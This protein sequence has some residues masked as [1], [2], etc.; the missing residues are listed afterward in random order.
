MSRMRLN[1]R[2]LRLSVAFILHSSCLAVVTIVVRPDTGI[3]PTGYS[4]DS[5]V[6]LRHG[7]VRMGAWHSVLTHIDANMC[8]QHSRR[9]HVTGR[10]GRG[11]RGAVWTAAGG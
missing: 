2:G 11:C 9:Q 1:D 7:V 3:A 10:S 5:M 4:H 8:K 6:W